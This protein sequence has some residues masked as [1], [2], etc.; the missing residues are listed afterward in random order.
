MMEIVGA[1]LVLAV[2]GAVILSGAALTVLAGAAGIIL[3]AAVACLLLGLAVNIV[4]FILKV[5]LTFLLACILK[6]VFRKGIDMLDRNTSL[7]QGTS[8]EQLEKISMAAGGA[9]AVWYMFLHG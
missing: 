1:V 2:L 8:E 3:A 4:G 5:M 7:L 9:V 6:W